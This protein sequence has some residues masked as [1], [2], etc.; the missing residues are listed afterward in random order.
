VN[1]VPSF[2]AGLRTLAF[3]ATEQEH[4]LRSLLA[5]ATRSGRGH[6]AEADDLVLASGA[7][8]IEA[9]RS[10]LFTRFDGNLA[11]MNVPSPLER[12]MSSTRLEK[13]AACPFAYLLKYVLGVESVDNPED[14]LRMT[15]IDRGELVHL[16][17][18]RFIAGVLARP[19]DEQ[20][21]PDDAWSDT[22]R[23]E[24]RRI[25]D[26]LCDDYEA[27]GRAGRAVFWHRDRRSILADLDRFLGVDDARRRSNRTR[28][29][30][31]ELQFGFESSTLGPASFP[32]TDGRVVYFRGK[33]DRV[34]RSDD[35]TIHVVDYKT[36]RTNAYRE[37]SQDNPDVR[38]TKLQL[39]VYGAAALQHR[40]APGASVHAEYW[41]VSKKG[42]FKPIGFAITDDVLERVGCTLSTMVAAIEAGVFPPHPTDSSTSIWVDCPYCDPDALGVIELQRHW[43]RKRN[44]P[45]LAPYAELTD[46][47]EQIAVSD[48][49]NPVGPVPSD[50][51]AH[52]ASNG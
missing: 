28:P 42:D 52:G 12:A 37:L 34:D 32:L 43:D 47:I 11:G 51:R 17:L 44:D 13:W 24:L 38:G 46:P 31:T 20:P 10:A 9:R 33:A 6:L 4:R 19:V 35:G 50:D 23:K 29:M 2:D 8:V 48:P 21:G 26:D 41:F 30:A 15:A 3:P 25:G 22:D 39:A 45:A 7:A 49:D 5:S 18:E 14:E 1:H 27:R 40:A 16:A 36:G